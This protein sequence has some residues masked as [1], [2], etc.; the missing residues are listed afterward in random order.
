MS[1]YL[2]R[3]LALSDVDDRVLQ[4]RRHKLSGGHFHVLIHQGGSKRSGSEQGRYN[5]CG[6]QEPLILHAFYLTMHIHSRFY[7][8]I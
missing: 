5:V 4:G 2:T 1:T 8:N 7:Y 3:L 6:K